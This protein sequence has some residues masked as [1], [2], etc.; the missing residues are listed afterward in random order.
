MA[1]NALRSGENYTPD[2]SLR[3]C[4]RNMQKVREQ[5]V[6]GTNY[7]CQIDGC[8]VQQPTANGFCGDESTQ[9]GSYRVVIFSQ[10]GADTQRVVSITQ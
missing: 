8:V 1:A 3:L 10:E 4:V 6:A 2:V 5:V 7:D 9:C